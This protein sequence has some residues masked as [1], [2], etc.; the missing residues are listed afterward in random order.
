MKF[1]QMAVV[2]AGLLGAN[3]AL[4]FALAGRTVTLTDQDPQRLAQAQSGWEA[5]LAPLEEAGLLR[6][7]AAQIIVRIRPVATLPDA[8]RN[9]DLVIE[10]VFEDL[11]LKRSLFGELDRLAPSHAV[12]GS[13]S[14]SLMPSLLAAATAR[15]ER[16][17]G[18]HYWNPAHLIPLVELI[19]APTTDPTLVEALR[20]MYA[21]IGKQP[22]VVRQ[23]V[24]GFIG[25]RLQFA[26]LRE[27]LALVEAGV[28]EPVDI[29]TV[30]RAGFGRRLPVTGL[31]ATADL[32]GLDTLLAICGLLFPDLAANAAP[33]P[34]LSEHV[35]AGRTGVKSG[36]GWYDYPGEEGAAARKRLSQALVAAL[37][38]DRGSRE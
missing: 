12:L 21:E 37:T 35:A 25:N 24:P 22:V 17:L 29:D 6:E 4:D 32:A 13:N 18:V 27:A 3:I 19:P 28:A 5:A 23:E 38:R 36:A 7:T 20:A 1:E 34:A 10:A 16:V 30:V 26:L 9:A 2:G 15:P 31:F 33:G 14:S 11:E 8:V